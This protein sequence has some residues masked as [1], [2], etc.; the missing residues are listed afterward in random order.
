MRFPIQVEITESG[1]S[2]WVMAKLTTTCHLMKSP[3]AGNEQHDGSLSGAGKG[4]YMLSEKQA[5]KDLA[6]FAKSLKEYFALKNK[7]LWESSS[8]WDTGAKTIDNISKYQ[9]ILVY[10]S[11]GNYAMRMERQHDGVFVGSTVVV[12]PEWHATL[13]MTLYLGNT[14]GIAND[15]TTIGVNWLDHNTTTGHGPATSSLYGIKKIIGLEP[16]LPQSLQNFLGGGVLYRSNWE[17]LLCL[18]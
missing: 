11:L 14:N 13:G 6:N 2:T 7:I 9:S 16:Y 18:V 12:Y 3:T 4:K 17:V 5:F 8:D 1:Q 10:T 15:D